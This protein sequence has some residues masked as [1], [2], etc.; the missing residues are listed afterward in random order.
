VPG[1]HEYVRLTRNHALPSKLWLNADDLN[2]FVIRYLVTETQPLLA[3][4]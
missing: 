1:E 4:K 2:Q 3:A